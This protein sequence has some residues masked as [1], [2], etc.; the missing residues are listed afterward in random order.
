[1]VVPGCFRLRGREKSPL[2]GHCSSRV[3]L[4]YYELLGHDVGRGSGLLDEV[5]L[6]FRLFF[7]LAGHVA[8]HGV[9][10]GE[11]PRA[12]RARHSDALVALSDVRAEVR[13]VAVESVA[14]RAFQLFACNA[15]RKVFRRCQPRK[16]GCLSRSKTS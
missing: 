8:P 7:V 14:V 5:V 12:E 6:Q 4:V 11:G 10:P 3:A 13:L 1:M 9:V 15:T 16:C 2:A